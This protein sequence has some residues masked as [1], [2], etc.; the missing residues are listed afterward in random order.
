[1][2]TCKR[3]GCGKT[4]EYN[5]NK[6]QCSYHPQ[7]PIFHEGLKGWACC[8]KRVISFDEFL[9]IPGCAVG[10]HSDL[11]NDLGDQSPISSMSSR[12]EYN[13]A[14]TTATLSIT[15]TV[16]EQAC[17]A[18]SQSG[19]NDIR[20]SSQAT[21]ADSIEEDPLDID[22]S[23]GTKCKRCGCNYIF[24]SKSLSCNGGAESICTFHSGTPV[25]HEAGQ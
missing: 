6:D 9:T 4:F 20:K 18:A 19:S 16:P 15:A 23:P 8:A 2:P 21:V 11:T 24:V 17:V 22:I 5:D 3:N 13:S 25:F 1:M 14:F 10:S 7:D 12:R